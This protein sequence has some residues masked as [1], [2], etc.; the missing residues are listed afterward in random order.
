M[1]R[2]DL[3]DAPATTL[4]HHTAGGDLAGVEHAPQTDVPGFAYLLDRHLQKRCATAVGGVVNQNID[5][6]EFRGRPVQH[7]LNCIAVGYVANDM[8]DVGI[9]LLSRAEIE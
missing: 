4:L 8:Q 7:S 5:R 1:N 6:P 9:R 3:N 2:T